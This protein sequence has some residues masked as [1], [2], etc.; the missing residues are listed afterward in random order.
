MFADFWSK[1]G[2]QQQRAFGTTVSIR[3]MKRNLLSIEPIKLSSYSQ[4]TA[5][6]EILGRTRTI[7]PVSGVVTRIL[8]IFRRISKGGTQ[9][10]EAHSQG[11]KILGVRK[12]KDQA[13]KKVTLFSKQRKK[14]L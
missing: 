3:S 1:T 13:M 6:R 5:L 12:R 2:I 11:K 9:K 7:G 10:S 8:W 4:R 14:R